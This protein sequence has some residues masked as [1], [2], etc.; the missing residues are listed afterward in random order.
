M[1]FD[2]NYVLSIFKVILIPIQSF[3]HTVPMSGLYFTLNG[4]VYHPG[5]AVI[6]TEIGDS[7]RDNAGSSLLCVTSNVNTECCRTSDGGNVGGWYFPNGTIVLR[8]N[9]VAPSH[10][11]TR[12]G[13]KGQVL[14][15]RRNGVMSPTGI[16]ECRVPVPG[17][18]NASAQITI[19]QCANFTHSMAHKM[20]GAEWSHTYQGTCPPT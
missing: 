16:Y 8:R 1:L 12:S 13:L 2:H 4:T 10:I 15:N 5:E 19:G 11:F 14:L 20:Q 17:A 7:T 6:I 9:S 18:G 3:P